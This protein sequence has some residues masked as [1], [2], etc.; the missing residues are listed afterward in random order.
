M[1]SAR[2]VFNDDAT[3]LGPVLERTGEMIKAAT[4]DIPRLRLGQEQFAHGQS[5]DLA[6]LKMRQ[7]AFQ[8]EQ[9]NALMGNLFGPGAASG[10]RSRAATGAIG[11]SNLPQMRFNYQQQRDAQRREDARRKEIKEN[12]QKRREYQTA[13][14]AEK[15]LSP[16]T[17][18]YVPKYSPEEIQK[19]VDGRYPQE[20]D[21]SD[22]A[23]QSPDSSYP[24]SPLGE[25]GTVPV[26]GDRKSVV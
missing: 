7:A 19:L 25:R 10:T 16:I 2:L 15:G 1:P 8:A 20:L 24:K 12:L 22:P 17:G 6:N 21:E 23:L 14:E 5:M 13:L 9:D 18:E 4:S 26:E 11:A 3:V